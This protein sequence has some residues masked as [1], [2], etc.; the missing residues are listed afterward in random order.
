[1]WQK[2]LENSSRI[3]LSWLLMKKWKKPAN[4]KEVSLDQVSCKMGKMSVAVVWLA[5]KTLQL[6][7]LQLSLNWGCC[8]VFFCIH[9]SLSLPLF[10]WGRVVQSWV[11]ITQGL[12]WNLISVLKAFKEKFSIILFVNNLM[13]GW[14]QKNKENDPKRAFEQRSKEAQIKIKPWVSANLPSFNW[15]KEYKRGTCKLLR[16]LDWPSWY[17]LCRYLQVFWIKSDVSFLH[18]FL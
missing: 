16:T 8:S 4:R 17:L 2:Q 18:F 6:K 12:V 5:C 7:G 10:P 15:A 9:L 13:I 14:S 3:G 1:M 11:K